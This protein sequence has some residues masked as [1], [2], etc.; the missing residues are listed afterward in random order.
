MVT[1]SFNSTE[2]S[3]TTSIITSTAIRSNSETKPK[4]TKIPEKTTPSLIITSI[5]ALTSDTQSISIY[6]ERAP[7]S[8]PLVPLPTP[9]PDLYYI[10][11]KIIIELICMLFKKF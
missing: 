2:V 1:T 6:I 4:E 11:E 3:T 5:Q 8:T 9:S 10:I 7:I